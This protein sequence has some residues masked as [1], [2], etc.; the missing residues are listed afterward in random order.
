MNGNQDS[1]SYLLSES[2]IA[3]IKRQAAQRIAE[4]TVEDTL[5]AAGNV[6]RSA[7]QKV[8]DD[9]SRK[10]GDEMLKKVGKDLTDQISAAKR[11]AK[12]AV[13][14]YVKN[15]REA[16]E[17]ARAAVQDVVTKTAQGGSKA[18]TS[19]ISTVSTSPTLK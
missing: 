4:A 5:R 11:K 19:T 18:S 7:F 14:K 17:I 1:K 12:E 13:K 8:R 2:D 15:E 3:L 6:A 10:V 16:E 9:V